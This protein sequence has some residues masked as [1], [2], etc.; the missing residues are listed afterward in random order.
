MTFQGSVSHGE[1]VKPIQI[2]REL[3]KNEDAWACSGAPA[4]VAGGAGRIVIK[5]PTGS[6]AKQTQ[7]L[8]VN[9]G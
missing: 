1:A 5:S 3:A 2:I 9:F 8:A 6:S 4:A 7:T